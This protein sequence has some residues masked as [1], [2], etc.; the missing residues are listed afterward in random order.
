MDNNNMN[1]RYLKTTLVR[2]DRDLLSEWKLRFPGV[3]YSNIIKMSYNTSALKLDGILREKNFK[4]KLGKA[5]YGNI[6]K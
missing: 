2:V 6:W 5:I 1:K 4:D 3:P